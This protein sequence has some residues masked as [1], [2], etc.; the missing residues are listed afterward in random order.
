MKSFIETI[1]EKI[2]NNIALTK[3]QIL[4][5]SHKHKGH[6]SFQEGKFHIKI[7]IESNELKSLNKIQAHK[8][9]MDILSEE[10]KEKIHALEIKIN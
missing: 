4:D 8:K 3:I 1:E 7:I 5:N 2:R 10:I 9:I 6:N